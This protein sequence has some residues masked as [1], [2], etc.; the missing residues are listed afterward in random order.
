MSIKVYEEQEELETYVSSLETT[1]RIKESIAHMLQKAK[2]LIVNNEG[3]YKS[4]REMYLEA[5]E[6]K[7]GIENKRKELTTPLRAEMSRINDQAKM[8]TDPLD[9]VI[10]LANSKTNNYE[11]L[12]EKMQKEEEDKVRKAAEMLNIDSSSIYVAPMEKTIRGD[13]VTSVSTTKQSFRLV[14]ITKVPSKYLMLD[15]K[16]IKQDLKLGINEISGIEIFEETTTQL[17]MR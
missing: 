2:S 11:L 12:L 7:K 17:R 3:S 9:E 4:I 5:R 1:G 13:G 8:L 6:W 16:A 10:D 14:D 15:E